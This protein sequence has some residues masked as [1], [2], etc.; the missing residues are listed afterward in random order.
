MKKR[1]QRNSA[2]YK[3]NATRLKQI[4]RAKYALNLTEPKQETKNKYTALIRDKLAE[5]VGVQKQLKVTFSVDKSLPNSVT[6]SGINLIASRRLVNLI[7]NIRKHCAGLFFGV[8]K[9]VN[10]NTYIGNGDFGE[11]YHE[12]SGEPYFYHDKLNNDVNDY[13]DIILSNI[14]DFN[15]T[16]LSDENVNDNDLHMCE[17]NDVHTNKDVAEKDSDVDLGSVKSSKMGTVKLAC[18]VNCKPLTYFQIRTTKDLKEAFGEPVNKFRG[19][20][21]KIDTGC[22]NEHD[23]Q[24]NC[25][26]LACFEGDSEC[27]SKLRILSAACPH[28][29]MLCTFL[30]NVYQ[31]MNYDN[32]ISLIDQALSEGDVD[33]LIK[34]VRESDPNK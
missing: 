23:P 21:K 25:H 9:K 13:N 5:N 11:Q 29:P 32:A 15:D 6:Q 3:K 27:T 24:K 10:S 16:I 28:Y 7:L 31:A 20:L 33:A 8:I 1:R 18:T 30:R 2:Y 26:P 14:N 4:R 19:V 34:I 17:S 12:A 22:P